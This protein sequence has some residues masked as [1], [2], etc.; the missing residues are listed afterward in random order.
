M[1][2]EQTA[3]KERFLREVERQL[4]RKGLDS[5]MTEGGILNVKWHGQ[6]LCDVDGDGVVCFPSKT[7]RGVDADASLQTVIQIAS[8]VREYMPIFARAPA[9]KAIGLEGS[10]KIL[11]DFGD[12]V[13][14]GRL[15]KKGAN[16]VTW[17]WDFDR[18]GVHMGR[19]FIE[20]YRSQ[21]PIEFTV[22][23]AQKY[24][25]NVRDPVQHEA[26]KLKGKH[27][28]VR[29][30]AFPPAFPCSVMIDGEAVID[31][32]LL[33]TKRIEDDGTAILTNEE[34]QGFNFCVVLAMNIRTNML[35]LTVTPVN[36]SN[37]ASLKYRRFLKKAMS[38][39][40]ISLK[41]LQQN[42]IIVSSKISLTLQDCDRI[43]DEIEFLQKVV[44]IEEQFHMELNIPEEITVEDHL[45]IDRLYAMIAFGEYD[46]V[47][48]KFTIPFDLSR[49]LRNAIC[50]FER[51]PSDFACFVKKEI[52]V[53]D[54]KI[55]V[56][57][58]RRIE[59]LRIEDVERIKAKLQ[60]LDDGDTIKI[61][62]ISGDSSPDIQYT[63]VLYSEEAERKFFD[64]AIDAKGDEE[65]AAGE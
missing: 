14:A 2:K 64:N 29:P 60:V 61:T 27:I 52:S 47:T 17:E 15:G 56:P 3:K 58:I 31:Y 42:E 10:Y 22:D 23:G 9:L 6:L 16:F 20:D 30:P 21:I 62:F 7:V 33:R 59:H 24:L 48:G 19:Y 38:A 40:N 12:A 11:A 37:G 51:K 65:N 54:Q 55:P 32:L 53:F 63:D 46:G 13:L 34:Q 36:P 50:D 41:S 25:G 49:E 45:I 1:S 5:E 18:N 8:Q 44:A 28:I 39:C 4:L 57:I 35:N 26:E 43:D